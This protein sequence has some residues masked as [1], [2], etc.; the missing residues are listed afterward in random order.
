MSALKSERSERY[1][2]SRHYFIHELACKQKTFLKNYYNNIPCE[3]EV[4]IMEIPDDSRGPSL[5]LP[6][7]SV[8]TISIQRQLL[9]ISVFVIFFDVIQLICQVRN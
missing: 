6:T 8:F 2:V 1:F 4:T 9:I 5:S 3:Q 7:V